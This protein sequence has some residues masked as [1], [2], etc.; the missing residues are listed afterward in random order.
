MHL[1][2][3]LGFDVGAVL[4]FPRL[5]RRTGVEALS[6][7]AGCPWVVVWLGRQPPKQ[8]R[9]CAKVRAELYCP[10]A[11]DARALLW[12]KQGLRRLCLLK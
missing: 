7:S 9:G 2:Y 4:S 5:S 3:Y 11:L 1:Y 6:R 8:Y 10:R 12:P